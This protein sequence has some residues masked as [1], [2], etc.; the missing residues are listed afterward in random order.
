MLDKIKQLYTDFQTN[1]QKKEKIRLGEEWESDVREYFF[2]KE[3][4]EI[5]EKTHSFAQ[6]KMDFVKASLKPDYKFRCR[7]TNRSFY[8]EC[9]S[10]NITEFYDRNLPFWEKRETNWLNK[11]AVRAV[12]EKHKYDDIYEI[13]SEDQFKR[14]KQLNNEDKVLFMVLFY[15]T[16]R[17]IFDQAISLIPIDNMLT[18][19]LYFWQFL[20]YAIPEA[21][22]TSY[23]LWRNFLLFYG[24]KASCIRCKA[25]VKF[26]TFNPLCHSCWEEWFVY[27]KFTYT[28]KYCHLCGNEHPTS[29]IK[30]LCPNC[31]KKFPVNLT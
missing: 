24:T 15:H 5:L 4:Y 9:K 8:I 30:P 23:N 11:E 31:Y 2:P 7:G 29:S 12:E 10:R 1:R 28:E 13:C 3:G 26:N 27:K 16:N 6:N 19:R 14:Y 17:E 21:E 22:I 25:K 20:E 18:N